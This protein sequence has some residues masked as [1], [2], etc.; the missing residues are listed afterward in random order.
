MSVILMDGGMGQELL[1]RSGA[2]PTPLWSAE[3]M[4][5]EPGLVEDLHLDFIRAGARTITVNAYSATRP[6]LAREGAEDRFEDL[7]RA[8]CE[9]AARARDRSGEDVT[10]TG[11]LP[12][13]KASYRPEV[14]DPLDRIA[15]D[16]AEIAALQSPFVDL[17]LAETMGSAEEAKGAAQGA[18]AAAG[19][20]LWVAWTV[21]DDGSARLRSGE[22][23][24][25][26]DAALAGL[27]VAV[28]LLNCS[29]PEAITAAMGALAALGGP[30]GAYANGFSGISD[31]FQPGGTVDVLEARTDLGPAAYADHAMRWA[32]A[33]AAVVGGCCEVGPEH[34]AELRRRLE[35]A[36]H[37]IKGALG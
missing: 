9:A 30:F 25:D 11:C 32:E 18:A 17:M 3:V 34:I 35:A 21:E 24:A 28:R 13:L 19:K 8:A 7:Q 23:L 10:I 15:A 4:M 22:T 5:R 14:T 1:R 33:G 29:R 20:P 6:K 2:R 37:E 31:A 26:A 12:P 27:P 16:Y 36:G